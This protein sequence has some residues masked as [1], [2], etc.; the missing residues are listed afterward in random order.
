MITHQT[1]SI[2][3]LTPK[4]KLKIKLQLFLTITMHCLVPDKVNILEKIFVGLESVLV[5]KYKMYFF[6]PL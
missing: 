1:I 5:L 3:F 2:L 4:S 6:S